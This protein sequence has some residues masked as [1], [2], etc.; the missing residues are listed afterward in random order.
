MQAENQISIL[1]AMESWVGPGNKATN[2]EY[3]IFVYFFFVN[4]QNL[5]PLSRNWANLN[6]GDAG[7]D[8]NSY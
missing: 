8:A 7:S 5:K 3:S 2:K 6:V 1:Q 4:T